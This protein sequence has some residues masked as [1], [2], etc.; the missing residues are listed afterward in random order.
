LRLVGQPLWV[1][2]GSQEGRRSTT[3][4][5]LGATHPRAPRVG[6]RVTPPDHLPPEKIPGACW[7][8]ESGRALAAEVGP[9]TVH[10]VETRL[11]D[12]VLDRLPRVIRVLTLRERVGTPRLDAACARALHFG[13]LTSR[14]R[15]RL[16]DRGLE[17]ERLPT[18]SAPTPASTFV[19]TA[20]EL[21]G[22]LAGGASWSSTIR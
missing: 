3:R 6:A 11:A 16:L 7:T 9:A 5:A 14:T 4:D 2:G 19:R 12:P 8:R 21:L 15:T 20:A 10:L 1:R 18:I 22:D 17:A 13:D